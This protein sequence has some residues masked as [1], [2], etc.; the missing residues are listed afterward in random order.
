MSGTPV[1]VRRFQPQEYLAADHEIARGIKPG[2][3]TQLVLEVIDP[4]KNAVSYQ[5]D[6]L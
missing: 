4:G 2:E 6:F 3:K 1:S 5:F